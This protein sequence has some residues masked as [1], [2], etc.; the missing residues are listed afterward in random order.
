MI[1]CAAQRINQAVTFLSIPR[2]FL[3]SF[4]GAVINCLVN[5]PSA[6]V[7]VRAIKTK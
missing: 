4:L 3:S 6:A 2:I 1:S 7:L 5:S